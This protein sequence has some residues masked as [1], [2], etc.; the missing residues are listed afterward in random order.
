VAL[1][2]SILYDATLPRSLDLTIRRGDTFALQLA[3]QNADGSAIDLT[4]AAGSG[5][6]RA[7][8][9]GSIIAAFTV[10]HDNAGGIVTAT[11]A[12][13]VTAALSWPSNAQGCAESAPLGVFDIQLAD[14]ADVK[15]IVSGKAYLARDVVQ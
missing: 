15:T 3:I 2:E 14:G 9:D 12:A 6:I 13:S 7:G 1:P 5:A 8:F 10:S 11:I 4:G